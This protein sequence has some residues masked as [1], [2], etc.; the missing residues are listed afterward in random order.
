MNM[1]GKP[2][3]IVAP[4]TQGKNSLSFR[5]KNEDNARVPNGRGRGRKDIESQEYILIPFSAELG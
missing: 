1:S 2:Q 4:A 5:E 3:K